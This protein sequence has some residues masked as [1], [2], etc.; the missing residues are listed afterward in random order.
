[1]TARNVT[2]RSCYLIIPSTGETIPTPSITT[3]IVRQIRDFSRDA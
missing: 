1:M 3:K 2:P